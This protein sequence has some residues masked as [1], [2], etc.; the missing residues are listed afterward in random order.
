MKKYI[1]EI[2]RKILNFL[3]KNSRTPLR[4]ISKEVGLMNSAVHVRIEKLKKEGIIKNFT[5]IVNPEALNLPL[6][7]FVLIKAKRGEYQEVAEELAKYPKILE[8]Y[9]ITGKYDIILKVRTRN[10]EELDSILDSIGNIKG[11]KETH[12]M[13][14]LKTQKNTAELPFL[15]PGG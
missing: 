2:D 1:D 13:V 6:L 3:Q 4:K 9:E 5:V 11:V 14:V 10:I 15:D 12:T 8:V 7:A